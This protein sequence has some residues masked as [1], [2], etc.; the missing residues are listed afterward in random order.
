MKTKTVVPGQIQP[1]VMKITTL[2]AQS[3]S[4]EKFEMTMKCLEIGAWR[5]LGI[6]PK[7]YVTVT[8]DISNG[9]IVIQYS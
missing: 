8:R 1:L 4:K 5:L 3:M 9:D 6:F 7:K 2:Q